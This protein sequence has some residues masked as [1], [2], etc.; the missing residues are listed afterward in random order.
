MI[1][2]LAN[3][4]GSA[5][6]KFSV[7]AKEIDLET[8]GVDLKGDVQVACEIT[9]HIIETVVAGTVETEAE[10]DCT[11][12]LQPVTQELVVPFE[13]SFVA[14]DAFPT[15]EEVKLNESDL[16]VDVFQGEQIDLKE[17]AREQILLN[18]PEQV[19]CRDDCKGLCEKCGTNLNTSKCSC[20][21]DEID[22][23]WAALQGLKK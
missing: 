22:P 8:P 20:G 11:R 18:L 16:G 23:R 1:V 21:E 7:P 2:D 10:I 17:V 14:P 4:S 6:Y 13:V 15:A 19:T 9:R 5:K 3:V 12:C